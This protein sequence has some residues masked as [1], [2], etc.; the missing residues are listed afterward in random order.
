MLIDNFVNGPTG[1]LQAGTGTTSDLVSTIATGTIGGTRIG[2]VS[3]ASGTG[4]AAFLGA[5]P[6]DPG[7]PPLPNTVSQFRWSVDAEATSTVGLYYG[8]DDYSAAPEEVNWGSQAGTSGDNLDA[9]LLQDGNDRFRVNVLSADLTDN[10]N[11]G[12]I[13]AQGTP[14][15]VVAIL[16]VPV[17]GGGGPPQILEFEFA[18]FS[19]I[20]GPGS[21]IDWSDIDQIMVENDTP[22]GSADWTLGSI[23]VVPEPST[24]LLGLIGLAGLARRRR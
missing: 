11:I 17:V 2:V 20:G 3:V 18:A 13:S 4:N 14:D 12:V 10:L 16:S 15:E 19:Q 6:P 21:A 9:D 22:L 24:A 7:P 8:F 1:G 5:T 23:V